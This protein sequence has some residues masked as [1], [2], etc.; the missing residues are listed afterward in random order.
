MFK[1]LLKSVIN[2]TYA[3]DPALKIIGAGHGG[4]NL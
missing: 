3:R 2:Q 1:V 4:S